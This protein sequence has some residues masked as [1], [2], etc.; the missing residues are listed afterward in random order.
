MGGGA[1]YLMGGETLNITNSIFKD[2]NAKNGI[3]YMNALK[4]FCIIEKSK[5]IKNKA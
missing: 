1:M 5:F 4:E 3:I 2:N